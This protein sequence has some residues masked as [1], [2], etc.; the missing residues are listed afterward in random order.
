MRYAVRRL[1]RKV[2]WAKI[3][4]AV[5]MSG[6]QADAGLDS[7]KADA[8]VVSLREAVRVCIDEAS[9]KN[10]IA[11]VESSTAVALNSA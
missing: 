10:A 8:I 1:R 2:P 6:E 7:V 5:W 4:L 9:V 3:M 11:G